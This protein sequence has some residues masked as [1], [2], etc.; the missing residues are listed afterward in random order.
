[1]RMVRARYVTKAADGGNVEKFREV[2]LEELVRDQA[3][4]IA[5]DREA[6][7][8]RIEPWVE[9]TVIRVGK[10]DHPAPQ[11]P[12][13]V[14]IYKRLGIDAAGLK[15]FLA[16]PA[17]VK[18]FEKVAVEE[19]TKAIEVMFK[20]EPERRRKE[21]PKTV[22]RMIEAMKRGS[23]NLNSNA[24]KRACKK[25]GIKPTIGGIKTFLNS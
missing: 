20:A 10:L 9:S 24:I 13:T 5:E 8:A 7:L 4:Q 11:D 16:D 15:D 21:V 25:L 1:M 17:N 22:D 18:Q 14:S 6:N 3:K 2:Y 12:N 23:A 19:L